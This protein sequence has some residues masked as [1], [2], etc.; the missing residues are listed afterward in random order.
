MEFDDQHHIDQK[1]MFSQIQRIRKKRNKISN[2]RKKFWEIQG[3]LACFRKIF[4]LTLVE[5]LNFIHIYISWN[6]G[7]ENKTI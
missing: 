6:F 2:Y 4:N 1:S 3:K 7:N 5:K